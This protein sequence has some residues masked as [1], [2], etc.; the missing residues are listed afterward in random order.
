MSTGALTFAVQQR[1]STTA[2]A[3]QQCVSMVVEAIIEA[4]ADDAEADFNANEFIAPNNPDDGN[5]LSDVS[6]VLHPR[7]QMKGRLGNVGFKTL[8]SILHCAFFG[9]C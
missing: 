8:S 3:V 6:I 5:A 1:E 2:K 4:V 7:M 9:F